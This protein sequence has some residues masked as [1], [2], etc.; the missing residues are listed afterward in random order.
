MKVLLLFLTCLISVQIKSQ[1]YSNVI[2]DK[3]IVDFIQWKIEDSS[4]TSKL[5]NKF[6]RKVFYK[7]TN[8]SKA[9]WNVNELSYDTLSFERKFKEILKLDTI[10]TPQDFI[11]FKK[12]YYGQK[13]TVW[14]INSGKIRFKENIN[15]N[16]FKY[17]IPIFSVDYKYALVWEYFYC[18]RLCA[19]SNLY[20]YK[21]VDNKWIEYLWINGW[22]S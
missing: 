5:M 22:I 10:F 12:Q 2:L 9:N 8:W 6:P 1:T 19:Y 20:I 13:D 3:N 21:F 18:G 17:T 4:H 15:I 7:P 14:K 11:F 16:F